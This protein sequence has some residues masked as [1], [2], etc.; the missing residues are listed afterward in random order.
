MLQ[1]LSDFDPQRATSPGSLP[2]VS[3][4]A[5]EV[6]LD[7]KCA[8]LF[9]TGLLRT[10]MLDS[11]MKSSCLQLTSWPTTLTTQTQLLGNVKHVKMDRRW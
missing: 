1:S 10:V 11:G 3:H 4:N 2:V 9:Y 5:V 8:W 7:G 6:D